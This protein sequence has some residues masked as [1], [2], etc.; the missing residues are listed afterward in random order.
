MDSDV[1]NGYKYSIIHS[2][3]CERIAVV[4]IADVIISVRNV[5]KEYNVIQEENNRHVYYLKILY[6]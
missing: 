4:E 6:S 3:V 1:I 2:C 5:S